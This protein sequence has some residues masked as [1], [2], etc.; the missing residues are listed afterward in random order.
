MLQPLIPNP[1]QK[2]VMRKSRL[3]PV[4]LILFAGC[5]GAKPDADAAADTLTQAQRTEKRNR[6]IAGSQ[7]PGHGAVG[8]A[9]DLSDSMKKRQARLD[10]ASTR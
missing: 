4:L 1:S 5:S 9:L 6:A 2:V 3:M 7:I 8:K 10:S